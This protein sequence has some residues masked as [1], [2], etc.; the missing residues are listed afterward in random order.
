MIHPHSHNGGSGTNLQ[1]M[2]VGLPEYSYR[3]DFNLKICRLADPN[4]SS[5]QTHG[6]IF[7]EIKLGELEKQMWPGDSK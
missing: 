3:F 6:V 4:Q 1:E 7:G 2:V 5:T